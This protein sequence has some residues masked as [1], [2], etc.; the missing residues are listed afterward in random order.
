MT[1]SAASDTDSARNGV[2]GRVGADL[3]Q[4]LEAA[5]VGHVDVEQDDVGRALA[6]Q[7]DRLGHGRGVADDVDEPVE[8]GAHAGAKQRV[9]VDE[10]DARASAPR[11]GQSRTAAS[12]R[13]RARA[14]PRSAAAG[15][16]RGSRRA[17]RGAP[18]ARRSTRARRGGRPARR[19]GRSPGRGRGRRPPGARRRPRRRRPRRRRARELRG[20]EHRLAAA[21]TSASPSRRAA[22]RRPRRRRS[23]RRGPPRRP[24]AA[25]CSAAASRARRRA[26]RRAVQPGAQLALLPAGERGDLARVV[27]ALLHQRERLQHRV[28]QVGGDLGALLRADALGALGVQRRTGA[29]TTARR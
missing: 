29:G 9:V 20:V 11:R 22:R 5:A 25:A 12:R 23:R 19:R 14:R 16:R 4:D 28:V 10:H 7:R 26:R 15:R 21:A 8:L 27:G 17:R 24:A 1:S 3:A 6:D 13:A 2:A 18:C